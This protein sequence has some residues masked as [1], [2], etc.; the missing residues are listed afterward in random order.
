MQANRTLTSL[1]LAASIAAGAA[2]T[3][4]PAVAQHVSFCGV[5]RFTGR[6]C[7]TVPGSGTSAGRTFDISN[8]TPMPRR[9]TT[10]AGSGTLRG[11]SHCARA[12]NRLAHV[13]WRR[14]AVCPLTTPS[15]R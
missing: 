3:T 7:A 4:G 11:I 1:G 14:V 8:T 13:S 12:N 10:I 9:N 6:T 2:A 5:V 15:S